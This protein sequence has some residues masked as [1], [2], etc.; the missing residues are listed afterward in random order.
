MPVVSILSTGMRTHLYIGKLKMDVVYNIILIILL[1][2]FAC[3][4]V[5][6][7]IGFAIDLWRE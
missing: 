2:C 5:A 7:A 6:L 3:A 1:V 4:S